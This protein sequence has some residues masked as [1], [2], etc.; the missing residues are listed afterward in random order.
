MK[1]FL[2]DI[3]GTQRELKS[4]PLNRQEAITTIC[5]DGFPQEPGVIFRFVST[6]VI[7]VSDAESWEVDIASFCI[8]Y[9]GRGRWGLIAAKPSVATDLMPTDLMP[10]VGPTQK[11]VAL[12]LE[13]LVLHQ[14]SPRHSCVSFWDSGLGFHVLQLGTE[15][16]G[17]ATVNVTS[18]KNLADEFHLPSFSVNEFTWWGEACIPTI[19]LIFAA[20]SSLGLAFL[21]EE[22]VV[23]VRQ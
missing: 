7:V 21:P 8:K 6:D 9:Y 2:E 18:T 11:D 3:Y 17:A 4:M 15:S 20:I 1:H 12:W 5:S 22:Q 10:D 23:Q 19:D 14:H 13:D 16:G